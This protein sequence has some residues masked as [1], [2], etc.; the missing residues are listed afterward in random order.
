MILFFHQGQ[1]Q[2]Q[3]TSSTDVGAPIRRRC[4]WPTALPARNFSAMARILGSVLWAGALCSTDELV[5]GSLIAVPEVADPTGEK[6]ES[7]T[8]T[9]DS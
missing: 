4:A 2:F 3:L 1:R 5:I 6:V 7:G 9:A 8:T